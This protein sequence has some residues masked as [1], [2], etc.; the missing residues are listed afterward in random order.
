MISTDHPQLQSLLTML[1]ASKD[2]PLFYNFFICLVIG[3]NTANFWTKA[4][5]V[6]LLL[7]VPYAPKEE[8]LF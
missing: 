7:F 4:S 6:F 3:L 2:L 1:V 5:I 8:E